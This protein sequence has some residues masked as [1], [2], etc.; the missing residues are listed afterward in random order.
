MQ[1]PER[2]ALWCIFMHAAMSKGYLP[3]AY[4]QAGADRPAPT[5]A[6]VA[7]SCAD[8]AVMEFEKRFGRIGS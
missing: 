7:A 5:E 1:N 2:A 4:M 8:R 6:E 3:A